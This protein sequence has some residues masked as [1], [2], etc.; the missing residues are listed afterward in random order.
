MGDTLGAAIVA[1]LSVS[2]G[3]SPRDSLPTCS[4]LPAASPG[5][6][7]EAQISSRHPRLRAQETRSPGMA[8]QCPRGEDTGTVISRR[9][10]GA[11][12]TLY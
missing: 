8:D 12:G 5:S 4:L 10:T 2:N 6:V 1:A 7:V 3:P 9:G 11:G